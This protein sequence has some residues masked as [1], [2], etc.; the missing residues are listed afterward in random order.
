MQKERWVDGLSEWIDGCIG[1][2]GSR[3]AAMWSIDG[4]DRHSRFG[5]K[6]WLLH[7][8]WK[9]FFGVSPWQLYW[10]VFLLYW[11]WNAHIFVRHLPSFLPLFNLVRCKVIS[12]MQ[13]SRWYQMKVTL[14]IQTKSEDVMSLLA[15]QNLPHLLK[16]FSE[17]DKLYSVKMSRA[18]HSYIR[19]ISIHCVGWLAMI[20]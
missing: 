1:G 6:D 7:F 11:T 4:T 18:M 5:L 19:I 17:A 14:F 12:I 13:A 16:G 3:V 15:P 10:M 20:T 2:E 8:R 9:P